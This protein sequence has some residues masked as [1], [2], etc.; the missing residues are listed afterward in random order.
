L[1]GLAVIRLVVGV[2]FLRTTHSLAKNGVQ[3]SP[4]HLHNDGLVSLIGDDN[5]FKYPLGH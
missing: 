2:V 1:T 5:A 4:L 3:E